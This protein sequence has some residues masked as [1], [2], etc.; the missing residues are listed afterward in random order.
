[1]G[2]RVKRV[3]AVK[4]ALLLLVLAGALALSSLNA[5]AQSAD[6]VA[7]FAGRAV[8]AVYFD[9]EGRRAPAPE[10]MALVD[11]RAGQPLDLVALRASLVQLY[12]AGRFDDNSVRA[13][14]TSGGIDLVFDLVPRHPIDRMEFRGNLGLSADFLDRE[15]RQRFGGLPGR[16]Q[17]DAAA[18]AVER[19]LADEGYRSAKATT[20]IDATHDPGRERATLT[21]TVEAGPLA[22]VRSAKVEG[23]PVLSAADVL[24]RADVKVGGAYRPRQIDAGLDKVIETLRTRGYYEAAATHTGDVISADGRT[25]DVVLSVESGSPVTLKL[26]GDPVPGN[27]ND[28]VPVRREGSADEDLLEDSVRRIEAALRR[29][30]YW[31]AKAAYTRAET[32]DG[33][34]VTINVLRGQR[35]R[36]DRLEV[37]GNAAISNELIA[38]MIGMQADSV[39]DASKIAAGINRISTAYQQRGYAAAKVTAAASELPPS[40]PGGEPRVV[41]R[42]TIEEGPLTEVA[43]VTV[44]GATSLTASEITSVMRLQ[45]G[46]P[47]VAGFVLADRDA[48]KDLYDRHGYSAAAVDVRPQLSEDKRSVAMRVDIVSEGP[49]TVLDRVIVVGNRR[50]SEKTILEAVALTPGQALGTADRIKLQQRLA[51]LQL[52]RRV[53]ITEAP[54]SSGESGTDIIITVEESTA[55]NLSVG[56][57]VEAGLRA[58]TESIDPDGTHH[59]VDK[60]E[61]AP[62]ASFEVGRANLWGKNRSISLFSGIS[63]R[64]KDDA[65]H[66]DQDGKCCGFSEYRVIGSYR[67]RRLFGWVDTEGLA[68]V[69]AEQAIRNSFTFNKRAGA[70]QML[71][72]LPHHSTL[73]GSYSLQRIDL[74]N[75][76]IEPKDRLLVDRLFPQIR[77]SVFSATLLHDTRN[78]PD[79]I[80]PGAGMLV[81]A[82]VDLAAHAIG[83]QQGFAKTLAQAFIY[84]RIPSAPRVVLA[85]GARMGLL[86][87]FVRTVDSVDGA[88]KPLVI[89]G[90]QQTE[91][92]ESVHLSQRFFTGGSNSV[93]GF[94]LDRLAAPDLLN[95]EGLSNGGN[96]LLVF[97]AEV[98][99]AI[100]KDIGFVVFSDAGNVFSRVSAMSLGELRASLGGGLRYK[101]PIGP[102]RVDVG[103]KLGALRITDNRRWEFHFSIGEAF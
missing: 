51:E 76:R 44:T 96:G 66:P 26:T 89:N 59:T 67:E 94:G 77:L 101:S 90:V 85:G 57:G 20:S 65:D 73:V 78:D 13:V 49:R 34:V 7:R 4:R 60:L 32:P 16:A 47:F 5:Y 18:R 86:R 72:R 14:E 82:D 2:T 45:R 80:A 81:S 25:V 103:W 46:R 50:V 37:S 11:V 29:E 55:T 21:L 87:G 30:G 33:R 8:T 1:M 6:P 61:F 56:G 28:L 70:L 43:E 24:S 9:F 23:K 74:K 99:T 71:R 38:T 83:S 35:Y 63:L 52:F 10:L 93:R 19:A 97:N 95:E 15:L 36:F 27:I 98:R 84:R 64:P 88:G 53:A 48:I 42:I 92:V 39:F 58:R 102:L 79:A 69:S 91:R 75:Q 54:H 41:E 17:V 3:E 40:K 31:K 68:S 100:T 62:R 22:T 12:S